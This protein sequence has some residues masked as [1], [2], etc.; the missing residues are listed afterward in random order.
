MPNTNRKNSY[1]S[2]IKITF[3]MG[4]YKFTQSICES[5]HRNSLGNKLRYLIRLATNPGIPPD[6]RWFARVTS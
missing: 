2:F 4:F 1:R 5:K 6:S 3:L